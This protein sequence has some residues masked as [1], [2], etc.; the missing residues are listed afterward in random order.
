[1]SL[2][3]MRGS[4]LSQNMS[5]ISAHKCYCLDVI[6]AIVTTLCR[7]FK[8]CQAKHYAEHWHVLSY[9]TLIL[10]LKVWCY[11]YSHFTDGDDEVPKG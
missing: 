7:V 6:L 5:G 8:I 3:M 1:M 9:G 10:L 11:C 4:V 2:K